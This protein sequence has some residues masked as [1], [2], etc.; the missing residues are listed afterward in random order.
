M[1]PRYE[2]RFWL[3]LLAAVVLAV[4]LLSPILLPFV[5][6][7]AIGYVVDPVVVRLERVGFSRAAAAGLLVGGSFGLGVAAT[8]L[9]APLLVAQIVDLAA[10]LPEIVGWLSARAMP[11]VQH[12]L[13]RAAVE[14]PTPVGDMITEAARRFGQALADLAA[15]AFGQGMALVNLAGL[16][17]VTPLVAFYLLRD[18]PKVIAEIDS[19]L[20]RAHVETIRAQA[21]EIDLVLAGFAR[22]ATIVCAVSGV[23]YALAL[24]L[25]GLDFGL[26]IGLAAGAVSF[27]PYLGAVLGFVASVGTALGQFWPAWEPMAMVAGIFLGGQI[28]QDYVLT[29]WL[30]GDRTRLHPLWVIFGMLAGATLFGFVGLLAAVPACAAIGVL[31]RF[32][33]GQYRRS[34]IYL[35][36]G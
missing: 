14:Q 10:R 18:W 12:W 2:V 8:A 30:V 11:L 24:T 3:A 15:G 28:V 20:P 4:W 7:M 23:F 9:V 36:S 6:G 21:R 27:V 33:I 5:L 22:G 29:P 34:G 26:V 17:S 35:G 25:V 13:Q 16:L 32:A 31:A 1:M 19:W